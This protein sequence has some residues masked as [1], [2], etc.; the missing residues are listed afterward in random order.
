MK[1]AVVI[2]P[3]TGNPR[4]VQAIKS[5]YAQSYKNVRP[6]IVLDGMKFF[7]EFALNVNAPMGRSI[8]DDLLLLKD[9]TGGNG[10]YGHRVYAGVSQLV[11]EDYVLFLDQD[12]WYDEDHVESM[13]EELQEENKNPIPQFAYSLRKIVAEDGTFL[14]NDNC[15]SLGHWPVYGSN[16]YHI[17]TSAYAFRRDFL[18][19]VSHLWHTGY[20]GDR[21]FLSYMRQGLLPGQY[22]T[23]RKYSLNYRLDGN[24]GSA[25]PLFFEQGNRHNLMAFEGQYPWTRK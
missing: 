21:Q 23:N 11:N 24:A 1:S 2:I 7:A 16:H 14:F 22:A 12:N 18:I 4:T 6:L 20:G 19:K 17:D 15:E 8:E 25:S 13:I 3:T 5:V 9:N 10:F